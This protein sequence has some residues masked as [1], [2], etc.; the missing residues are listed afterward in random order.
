MKLILIFQ[1]ILLAL[2]AQYRN[3]PSNQ[4][5]ALA[6][7]N[8]TQ[9]KTNEA[10]RNNQVSAVQFPCGNFWDGN[11]HLDVKETLHGVVY[12]TP[13]CLFLSLVFLDDV[14]KQIWLHGFFS[15]PHE[16]LSFAPKQTGSR[17][18]CFLDIKKTIKMVKLASPTVISVLEHI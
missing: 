5:I 9:S 17:K 14:L 6:R 11:K 13:F 3:I 15:L 8:A 10:G 1:M 16:D 7:A 12:C 18:S 2:A 4:P